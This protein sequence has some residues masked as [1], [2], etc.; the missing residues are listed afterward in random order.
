ME[1]KKNNNNNLEYWNRHSSSLQEAVMTGKAEYSQSE[2][3]NIDIELT[4]R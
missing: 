4:I 1:W 3:I 2:G